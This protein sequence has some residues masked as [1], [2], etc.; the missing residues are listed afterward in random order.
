[1]ALLQ[2]E[3]RPAGIVSRLMAAAVDTVV[4][5]ALL[6]AGY[7]ALAGILF[8]AD[9]VRFRFPAPTRFV[10]VTSAL[11]VLICY[12]TG[13]W[14]TAGR[15]CG[16]QVLGLRVI[17]ADGRSPRPGR[18]LLRAVLCAIFPLGLLWVVVSGRRL[19]VQDLLLHTAVIYDWTPRITTVPRSV[20]GPHP[21]HAKQPWER[22]PTMPP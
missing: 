7:L 8:M 2:D 1:V 21:K 11:L 15:T 19:S 4:L 9:P 6:G 17:D 16:D 18:A 14:T 13:S 5:L 22:R 3:G 20:P 12:L 10:C